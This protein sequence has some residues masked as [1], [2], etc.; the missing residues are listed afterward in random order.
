MRAYGLQC[1]MSCNKLR[2]R[3]GVLVGFFLILGGLETELIDV[4]CSGFIL[5]IIKLCGD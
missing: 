1:A 3:F 4:S 2:L 5:A